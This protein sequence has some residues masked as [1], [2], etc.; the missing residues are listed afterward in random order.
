[1][2]CVRR[3]EGENEEMAKVNGP[4]PLGDVDEGNSPNSIHVRDN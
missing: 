4:G 1:M 2:P 3:D